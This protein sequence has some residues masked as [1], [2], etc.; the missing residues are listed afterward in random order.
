MCAYL[1]CVGACATELYDVSTVTVIH[2][3]TTVV[4]LFRGQNIFVVT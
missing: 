3:S 4:P 2:T 1:C